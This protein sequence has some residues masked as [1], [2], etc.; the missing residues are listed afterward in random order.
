MALCTRCGRQTEGAAEFCS[1]CGSYQGSAG[2]DRHQTVAAGGAGYLRPFASRVPGGPALRPGE[3][4]PAWASDSGQQQRARPPASPS[5][6]APA[7]YAGNA[8][9]TTP[10]LGT[11]DPLTGQRP[12][13]PESAGSGYT[14]VPRGPFVPARPAYPQDEYP[15]HPADGYQP[16]PPYAP[17]QYPDVIAERGDVEPWD[18]AGYRATPPTGYPTADT[19]PPGY[20]PADTPPPGYPAADTPLSGSRTAD[21]P[22][23]YS[24]SD[25]PPPGYRAASGPV[26]GAP[27]FG[28][29]D[30]PRTAGR[31]L[32]HPAG[33]Y[34]L[35]P[36][37]PAQRPAEIPYDLLAG[38]AGRYDQ[39]ADYDQP[40]EYDQSARHS[41]PA[42]YD[43]P[44]EYDQPDGLDDEAGLPP[45]PFPSSQVS[46]GSFPSS[47]VLPG[48]FATGQAPPGPFADMR[49]AAA[50]SPA[51]SYPAADYPAE[52]AWAN[53]GQ[54]G[55]AAPPGPGSYRFDIDPAGPM[56]IPAGDA[57]RRTAG[58][59]RWIS[60]AAAAVM[61]I[62]CAVSAVFLLSHHKPATPAG[63]TRTGSP[64]TPAA[65]AA[66]SPTVSKQITVEPAAASGPD[67]PA[68]VAFLARYFSAINHHDFAAYRRL[69]SVSLRGGLSSVA[70][71]TGYGSTRDS[72]ATLH[73]VTSAA[74]GEITAV[75][76]FT[77]HQQPA[78]SP[79]HAACTAWSI[80]L[81]L[82]QEGG[83]LVLVSPPA[84]YQGTFHGC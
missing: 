59:G 80:S 65:T 52:P 34:G 48:P 81:F 64:K 74:S 84:G 69:F 31:G 35:G 72:Q 76:T 10:G 55:A 9:F 67:A 63:A 1:G 18:S 5:G 47:Q 27:H 53:R 62:V 3:E 41:G 56:P 12:D 21:L 75:V 39:T 33:Q 70:F 30:D 32:G 42:G 50:E 68:V 45:G 78:A 61:L 54:P 4:V 43:Q 77:S 26:A 25:T 23:G 38:P 19:P 11:G 28:P 16:A 58:R 46:P 2:S 36:A 20:P 82:H 71:G 29:A 51:V 7:G 6:A 40:A 79:N 49:T 66:P 60:I 13:A 57:P 73:S 17:D 44:A 15:E 37:I 24:Q 22:P 83:S 8:G 14:L